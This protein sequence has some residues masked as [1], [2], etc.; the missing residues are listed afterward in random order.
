MIPQSHQPNFE[1][2][3]EFHMAPSLYLK[4]PKGDWGIEMW[5]LGLLP[6]GSKTLAE[7]GRPFGCTGYIKFAALSGQ[8]GDVK[9]DA[10]CKKS[11]ALFAR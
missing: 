10:S 5:S 9:S 1:Y 3:V 2:L 8:N 11:G 6:T 4:L 7:V